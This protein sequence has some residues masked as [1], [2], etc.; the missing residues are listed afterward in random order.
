MQFSL[1]TS[2]VRELLSP[3]DGGRPFVVLDDLPAYTRESLGLHGI[4]LTTDLL[5]GSTRARLEQFR[6]RADKAACACLTLIEPEALPFGDEDENAAIGA[7]ERTGRVLRAASVL[8][9]NSA[10]ISITSADDDETFESVVDRMKEV[11]ELAERLD[12]NVLITPV[13][14]L[15]GSPEKLT[16]LIKRIGGF[17][18]GTMPEFVRA[19]TDEDPELYLRRL[20][21]YAAMVTATTFEFELIE[22][23]PQPAAAQTEAEPEPATATATDEDAA[24]EAE[25]EAEL[26]KIGL[27]EGVDAGADDMPLGGFDK[28]MAMLDEPAE[29]YAHKPYA[30]EPLVAAVLS[31]GYDGMLAIEYRGTDD[32]TLGILRSVECLDAALEAAAGK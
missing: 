5:K 30:L 26:G 14:G 29:T 18:I 27:P 8:G 17:R 22:E 16:E 10:A 20:T 11:A 25:I 1:N 7:I 15:T 32:V 28:L 6:E 3:V 2:C 21:P 9:C 24:I 13:D 19:V 4:N 12:M 31:V 23:A